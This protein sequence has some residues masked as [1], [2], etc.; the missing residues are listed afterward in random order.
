[1]KYIFK[2][3][4]T[5]L[6]LIVGLVIYMNVGHLGELAQTSEFYL[7]LCVAAWTWLIFGSMYSLY[8]VWGN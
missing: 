7:M 3:A 8:L 5:L 6:L 2:I 4:I 1:M